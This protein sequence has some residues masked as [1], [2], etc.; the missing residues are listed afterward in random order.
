VNSGALSIRETNFL[1]TGTTLGFERSS[2]VDR[3][4]HSIELSHEHLFDGWTSISLD[5]AYASDGSSDAVSIVRPFYAL[6]T[7]W[8]AGLAGSRFERFDPLYQNGESV[9]RF[10]H[11]QKALEGFAGWSP[12]RIAGWT[13]RYSAGLSYNADTYT[14]D[15]SQPPP[16]APPPDRTL[17]GPFLRYEL[18]QDDFALVE[19]RDRIRRPEYFAMG[20]QSRVQIG[21]SLRAFGASEQPWQLN[22]TVSKGFRTVRAGQVLAS[23]AHSSLYGSPTGDVR[24]TGVQLRYFQPQIGSFIFYAAGALDSVKTTSSLEEL[25]LGGDNGVRG[26]PLRYQSG[27]RRAVFTVEERY[28]TDWYPLRLFRV[29]WAVYY[30]L[31]RAWGA[32]LP[33]TT[34]GWLSNVGVG[35][36]ILST[37]AS[38]GNVLHIDLAFPVHRTDPGIKARQFVVMTG[39]T[40]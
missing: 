4:G 21:R 32:E 27:T 40:F 2:S 10:R 25:R 5:H 29:G 24:S 22:A 18:V 3:H 11:E 36:R 23:A 34:P 37:R 17:A 28:Y 35:L 31:G 7:T 39:K 1:G 15:P 33:N 30:D 8:A 13:H 19:N 38:F 26:Y 16:A 9:G 12:G 6:E 20:F 14:P